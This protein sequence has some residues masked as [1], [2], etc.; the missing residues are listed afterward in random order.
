MPV[1]EEVREELKRRLERKYDTVLALSRMLNVK[2]QNVHLKGDK[3]Y[4]RAAVPNEQVKNELWNQAKRVDPR[5]SDLELEVTVDPKV[6]TPAQP[7]VVPP[8][9]YTVKRGD[10]L[11]DIADKFYGDPRLYKKIFD[12]NTD[13]LRDPDHIETGQILVIPD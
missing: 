12:A 8:R 10:T 5:I 2:L 4:I 13:R 3:L 11:W 7:R 6:A 9:T 1:K